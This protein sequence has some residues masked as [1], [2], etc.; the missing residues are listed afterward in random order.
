MID[1]VDCG[2]VSGMRID[3][4][5]EIIGENVPLF[6]FDHHKSHMTSPAL[7]LLPPRWEVND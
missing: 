1:D 3:R 6:R 7:E 5:T 4:E 2:R